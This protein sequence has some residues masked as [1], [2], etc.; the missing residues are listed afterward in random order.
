MGIRSWEW[1]GM[2]SKKSFP[3]I[4]TANTA[5]YWEKE[6]ILSPQAAVKILMPTR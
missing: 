2:G 3:Y 4:Y 6:P 5:P 1:E